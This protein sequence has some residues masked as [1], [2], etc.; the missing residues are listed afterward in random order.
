MAKSYNESSPETKSDQTTAV[1]FWGI[2][3]H[4]PNPPD[5]ISCGGTMEFKDGHLEPGTLSLRPSGSNQSMATWV[6][7]QP[8]ATQNVRRKFTQIDLETWDAT[9][10]LPRTASKKRTKITDVEC[11]GV[12][13]VGHSTSFWS[14]NKDCQT[15]MAQ[16][17]ENSKKGPSERDVMNI[18]MLEGAIYRQAAS[19]R[20]S[21]NSPQ[22]ARQG[23]AWTKSE[24]FSD[25]FVKTAI[26]NVYFDPGFANA[27][28][29]ALANQVAEHCMYP[30][31][32]FVPLR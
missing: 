26:N 2:A 27:G 28:G 25:R 6:K 15:W 14:T 23:L 11:S 1:A 19:S 17:G 4:S 10:K 29:E 21:G 13:I 32:R 30:N 20:D 9:P 18:C 8:Q 7:D 3:S 24:G 22:M 12:D 31:G 16:M 5:V